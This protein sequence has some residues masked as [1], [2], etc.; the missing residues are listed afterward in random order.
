[1][2]LIFRVTSL[3][4]R[5]SCPSFFILLKKRAHSRIWSSAVGETISIKLPQAENGTELVVPLMNPP[6][7]S[8]NRGGEAGGVGAM[9]LPYSI[10]L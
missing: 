8:L 7:P 2:A 1:M 9:G 10:E 5:T 4:R 3:V 6:L